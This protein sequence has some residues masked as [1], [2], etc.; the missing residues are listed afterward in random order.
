MMTMPS[1]KAAAYKA[2]RTLF[3]GAFK[4]YEASADELYWAR[5]TLENWIETHYSLE[6][7]GLAFELQ[8]NGATAV[9]DGKKWKV[10]E[11]VMVHGM[12][13]E[14]DILCF[15]PHGDKVELWI[16]DQRQNKFVPS[17]LLRKLPV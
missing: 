7:G 2:L 15:L 9:I 8:E 16:D 5:H 10:G 4:P 11:R 6:Q 12:S 17:G 3:D 13:D 14:G 1:D